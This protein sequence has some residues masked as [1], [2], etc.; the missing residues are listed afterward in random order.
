MSVH[1]DTVTVSRDLAAVV[2]TV[3][4][5]WS[6]AK[7]LARWY[8]PG[9]EGWSSEILEHAFR[10]G[11]RKHL[12]FG[13]KGETPYFEDCRYEDIVTDERILYAATVLQGTDRLTSSMVTIEFSPIPTGTRVLMTE[14]IA[15]LDG[16]D[17]TEER[18]Q[19]WQEVMDKLEAALPA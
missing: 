13:P 8:L 16:K 18:R 5:L 15:I 7:A 14:Q 11:G 19:G 3:F 1:H 4:G 6:D 17:S 2:P 10:V 9:D 12:S